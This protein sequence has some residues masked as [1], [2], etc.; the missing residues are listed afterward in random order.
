MDQELDRGYIRVSVT[1]HGECS[2]S[3]TLFPLERV[4]QSF[5]SFLIYPLLLGDCKKLLRAYE[6]T[7]S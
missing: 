6:C 5:F 7:V 4:I 1:K 3:Q 2:P